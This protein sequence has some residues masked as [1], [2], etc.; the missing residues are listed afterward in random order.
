MNFSSILHF[1]RTNNSKCKMK[2][3]KTSIQAKSKPSTIPYTSRKVFVI[4]PH[5]SPSYL[6]K[7]ISITIQYPVRKGTTV[8]VDGNQGRIKCNSIREICDEVLK[9]VNC[10]K[11]KYRVIVYNS[12]FELITYDS[13]LTTN[14][15]A[16]EVLYVKISDI[17]K[18]DRCEF[19]SRM[20]P[21]GV[22]SEKTFSTIISPKPMTPSCST[23]LFGLS[24]NDT[25]M[26]SCDFE[27]VFK[28]KAPPTISMTHTTSK[29]HNTNKI[30][31]KNL[32]VNNND[33]Y[34]SKKN[35]FTF[36]ND[37]HSDDSF[38]DFDKFYDDY[39]E[40]IKENKKL[41]LEVNK[42]LHQFMKKKIGNYLTNGEVKMFPNLK[43]N[44]I[45]VNEKKNFPIEK[46]KKKFIFFSFLSHFINQNYSELC[47]DFYKKK[48]FNSFFSNQ[49]TKDF[50]SNFS[51]FFTSTSNNKLFLLNNIDNNNL[52]ISFFFFLFF[53][54]YKPS[55]SLQ[56]DLQILFLIL[57]ALKISFG[58]SLS[59]QDFC[60][61]SLFFTDNSFVTIEQKFLFCKE[62][63]SKSLL[64]SEIF[65]KK[66]NKYFSITHKEVKFLISN[67]VTSIFNHKNVL[68]L[69]NIE[70]IYNNIILYYQNEI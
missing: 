28:P 63:I 1:H 59:F 53:V 21:N 38:S 14:S 52:K 13:Q 35:I 70:N 64:K 27:S 54:I 34:Y 23:S 60:V 29:L 33:L 67:N 7:N 22:N 45:L 31:I 43:C 69:H 16:N 17:I 11:Q 49:Q 66:I 20:K 32:D 48:C 12:K 2:L 5:S 24:E 50:I 9:F 15:K 36:S 65:I 4:F 62:I 10:T 19:H 41:F 3:T 44:F 26:L 6:K 51:S 55:L 8:G 18:G 46:L 47:Q 37:E 25:N 30:K 39:A 56:T 40:L 42:R 61:Y 68:Y 58:S 57:K